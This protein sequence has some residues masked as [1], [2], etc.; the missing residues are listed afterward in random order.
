MQRFTGSSNLQRI[1]ANATETMRRHTKPLGKLQ[2]GIGVFRHSRKDNS[3]LTFVEEDFVEA[4]LTGGGEID[5][6]A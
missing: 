6:P 2:N 4:P 5:F 1:A 3:R